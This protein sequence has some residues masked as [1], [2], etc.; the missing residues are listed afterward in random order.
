MRIIKSDL[1][2]LKCVF[3]ILRLYMIPSRENKV[4]ES[5][6][7]SSEFGTITSLSL[8]ILDLFRYSGIVV[9]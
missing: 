5:G 7:L 6:S 2:L 3:I 1:K 4:F 8:Y 9:L